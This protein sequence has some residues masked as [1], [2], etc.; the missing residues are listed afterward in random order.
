[1]VELAGSTWDHDRGHLPLVATASA[2][3]R[4]MSSPTGIVWAR[5]TLQD[6][7]D[8]PVD[9]LA[10]DYDLIVID[11]P[12][13]AQAVAAGVLVPLDGLI[14][15]VTL[16]DLGANTGPSYPSYEHEGRLWA[17]PVD[18]AVQVT[19]YRP[20]LLPVVPG[21]WAEVLALAQGSARGSGPRV[22][23]PLIAVDAFCSFLS[24]AANWGEPPLGTPE[25]VVDPA[26]G[27]GVL[28]WMRAMA[29]SVHP[30][31]LTSN[32]PALLD[33]MATTDEIGYMPLVFGY[34]NYSRPGY[35]PHR[36]AFTNIPSHGRGPVGAVLGGAGLALSS[37]CP[38][39]RWAARY[40]A[41]VVRSDVQRGLY[42]S[43]GGQPAHLDAW[44]DPGVNALADHFFLGT[45]ATLEA[46]H[47]RPR[48]DGFLAFQAS[49]GKAIRD[50]LAQGGDATS[51][52]N[53]LDRMY[54]ESR[55]HRRR[56]VDPEQ[57]SR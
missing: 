8:Y 48:Y 21:T 17:L 40:M 11:H 38:D 46:S 9:R 47:I 34:S 24:L 7:A 41:W 14:P 3:Q 20:D 39:P 26:V 32:P 55:D 31:S 42:F 12:A 10:R 6:F 44:R 19:V 49:A 13:I 53:D 28:E 15:T 1:M 51:V 16:E 37:R 50:F 33:L 29:R 4:Q 54:V 22:A 23:W 56:R 36:L 52:M 5:R 35:R 45:L 27:A 43:A 2:Y 25:R 18:A 57:R 30:L